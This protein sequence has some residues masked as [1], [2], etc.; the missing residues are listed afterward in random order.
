M[1]IFPPQQR[2]WWREPVARMEVV[3]IAIAFVWGLVMF[4]TMVAWHI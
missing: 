2:V 4:G 1:A 3:W